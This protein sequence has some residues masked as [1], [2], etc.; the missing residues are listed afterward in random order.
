MGM[1]PLAA[2][3]FEL[4]KMG[5]AAALDG[6]EKLVADATR[7]FGRARDFLTTQPVLAGVPAAALT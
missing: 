4:E 3:F 2:I 5:R 7:E 1:A 6:A